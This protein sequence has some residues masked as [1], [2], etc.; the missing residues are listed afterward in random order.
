MSIFLG[1]EF[2][3]AT[4]DDQSVQLT[5]DN[6]TTQEFVEFCNSSDKQTLSQRT[7]NVVAMKLLW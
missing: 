7:R 1:A 2:V 6:I 4:G 3:V 5:Y